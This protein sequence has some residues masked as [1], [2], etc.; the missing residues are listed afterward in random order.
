MSLL[1]KLDPQTLSPARLWTEMDTASRRL[2]VET[3]YGDTLEDHSAR[4]EV[5]AAIATAMRFRPGAVRKLPQERRVN[6]ALRALR[7][8]DALASTLLLVLHLGQR[9]E[10]LEA[11]LDHL[12]VAHQEGAIQDDAFEPPAAEKLSA[13]IKDL[14]ERFEGE[15][16]DLYLAALLAME[17][18]VWAALIP[19]LEQ[20]RA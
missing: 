18:D 20:R 11:F 19:T 8:D 6:Y 12:G 9:R 4:A 13:A 10:I 1:A 17:P 3:V 16:V 2:A 15:Q 5:D 7:P 14:Y